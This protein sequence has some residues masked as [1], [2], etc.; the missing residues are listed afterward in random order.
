[1]LI[2]MVMRVVRMCQIVR[3]VPQKPAI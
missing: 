1:M 3:D 2:E